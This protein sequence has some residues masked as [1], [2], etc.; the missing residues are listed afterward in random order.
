MLIL[1]PNGSVQF[2]IGYQEVNKVAQFDNSN[3]RPGQLTKQGQQSEGQEEGRQSRQ[4]N[5]KA[6]GHPD[7]DGLG[8]QPV[9]GER[10]RGVTGKRGIKRSISAEVRKEKSRNSAILTQSPSGEGEEGSG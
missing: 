2:C 5:F 6:K 7:L 10:K 9:M 1:K 3:M 4:A 8:D